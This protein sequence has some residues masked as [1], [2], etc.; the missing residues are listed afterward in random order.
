MPTYLSHIPVTSGDLLSLALTFI[1]LVE[2]D[3]ADAVTLE[4]INEHGLAA[5]RTLV[6]STTALSAAEGAE[7]VARA[8]Q[9]DAEDD[10]DDELREGFTTAHI[11]G[12][13]EAKDTLKSTSGGRTYGEIVKLHGQEQVRVVRDITTQAKA[14]PDRLGFSAGHLE[15]IEATNELLATTTAAR[16]AAELTTAAARLTRRQDEDSFTGA[17]RVVV[18]I[19]IALHGREKLATILPRYERSSGKKAAETPGA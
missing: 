2:T 11:R 15:R 3:T 7:R 10:S 14:A 18:R 8:E 5:A 19:L 12:G 6:A 16:Q 13:A 4:T 17:A 9:G 1:Q